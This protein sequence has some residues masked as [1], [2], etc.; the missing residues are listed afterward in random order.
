MNKIVRIKNVTK[1]FHHKT[2]VQN[3]SFSITKGEVVAIIGPNGA[4]KTTTISMILGLLQPTA[5]DIQLFNYK[6][7][8]KQVRG[9]IG[10]ML[11]DVSVIPGLKVCEI[12]ELIRSYY[13]DPLDKQALIQLTGLIEQDLKTR[14]EKLS[15]GQKRRKNE[16]CD[17]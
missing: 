9:K 13:P 16:P 12:I 2:A 3:I 8:E 11:Q 17:S 6:P 15:G 1:S 5:G 7:H 10:A 4:G 14:A